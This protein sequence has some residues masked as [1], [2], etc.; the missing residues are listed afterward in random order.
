MHRY[1]IYVGVS[2]LALAFGCNRKDEETDVAGKGGNAI[3]KITPKHHS[4]II[5]SCKVYI[6]Y[7]TLD[8]TASYDDST[9]AL[10]SNGSVA[11][12][13]GLKAGKY[14]IFGLGWDKSINQ[15]VRGGLPH[16][17]TE[18]KTYELILPVTEVH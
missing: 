17:I 7:N 12:F 8:A 13:Q 1:R 4:Q 3:L 2:L 5:D 18:Q 10:P 14:Y 15:E 16:T 6:K 9:W 11:V